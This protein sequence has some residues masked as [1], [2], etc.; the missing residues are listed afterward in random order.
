MPAQ[1]GPAFQLTRNGGAIAFDSVDGRYIFYSKFNAPGIWML[2]PESGEESCVVRPLYAIDSFAVT[3]D[4]IYFARR[5]ED[6]RAAIAFMSFSNWLIHDIVRINAEVDSTLS[7][8][9]DGNSLLYVQ[10]DQS[11]SDL[12]LVDNFE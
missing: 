1:G 5:T 9:P 10:A 7:L 2:S 11:G 6:N 8:S 12:V 4:G 3:K